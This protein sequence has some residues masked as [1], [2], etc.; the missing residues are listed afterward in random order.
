MFT[1]PGTVQQMISRLVKKKVPGLDQIINTA[2]KLLPKNSILA[3]TEILNDCL[4]FFY[5]SSAWNTVSITS[6][7]ITKAG[8]VCQIRK[9][10][11]TPLGNT[12]KNTPV[13][14]VIFMETV[15]F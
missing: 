6:I 14:K 4:K 13:N 11:T 15:F 10:T 2:L 12:T 9:D 8:I 5:F 1:A 3:L 7:S